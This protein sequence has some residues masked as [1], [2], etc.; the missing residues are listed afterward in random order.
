MYSAMLHIKH[1]LTQDIKVSSTVSVFLFIAAIRFVIDIS[2]AIP[3]L[4]TYLFPMHIMRTGQHV[5]EDNFLYY[6]VI[7]NW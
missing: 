3:E 4:K 2:T 1:E 5:P 7:W 6:C